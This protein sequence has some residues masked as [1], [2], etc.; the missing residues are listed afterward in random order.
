MNCEIS[1]TPTKDRYLD[2]AFLCFDWST[3]DTNPE[4][5][6][7]KSKDDI[8][9]WNIN[10]TE[11][12]GTEESFEEIVDLSE[13]IDSKFELLKSIKVKITKDNSEFI[14]EIP[15]LKIYAF[16][17]SYFEVLRE[18]NRDITDLFE[19]LMGIEEKK[20]GVVPSKWKKILSNYI[21]KS[22]D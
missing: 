10:A 13:L 12:I 19:E 1:L 16:G 4:G 14:A 7:S 15:E 6:F 3:V 9:I 8:F 17:E 18:V 2:P 20:L 5:A 21:Q 11:N 22:S